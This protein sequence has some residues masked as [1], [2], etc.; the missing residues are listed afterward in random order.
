MLR[1]CVEC[2]SGGHG[3]TRVHRAPNLIVAALDALLSLEAGLDH[4]AILGQLHERQ[5]RVAAWV[6]LPIGL[7]DTSPRAC[8]LTLIREEVE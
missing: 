4:L 7:G 6:S 8:L 3:G 5:R 2:N 1:I